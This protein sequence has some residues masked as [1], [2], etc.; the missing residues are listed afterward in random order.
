MMIRKLTSLLLASFLITACGGGGGGGALLN[1][2]PPTPTYTYVSQDDLNTNGGSPNDVIGRVL[3][4]RYTNNGA[5]YHM[6][7]A[8]HKWYRIDFFSTRCKWRS[9]IDSR[10]S[11]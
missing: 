8:K 7:M 2:T 11:A 5:T 9:I 4:I 3:A 10:P 1:N 6:E